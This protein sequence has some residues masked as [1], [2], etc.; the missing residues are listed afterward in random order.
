MTP[1]RLAA[2]RKLF[3][4]GMT[5]REIAPAIGVSVPTLYRHFPAPMQ[6]AINAKGGGQPRLV[7]STIRLA[8][9]ARS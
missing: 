5:I 4:S 2:A 3:A 9:E 7:A 6:E 1:K 8:R